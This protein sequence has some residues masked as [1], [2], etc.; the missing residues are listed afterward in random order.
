MTTL[1]PA[2]DNPDA[3]RPAGA[4]PVARLGG[5]GDI[6]AAVPWILGFHPRESLVLVS[7]KPPVGAGGPRVGLVLRLDLDEVRSSAAAGRAVDYLVEDGA[8]SLIVLVATDAPHRP[9]ARLPGAP[10]LRRVARAAQA[11][12][13][14][15]DEAVLVR[16]GR[17][18]AFDCQG[19]CCPADGTPYDC[20]TS[21][22]GAH[23]VLTGAV[24]RADREELAAS[25]AA[26]PPG[27]PAAVEAAAELDALALELARG[28]S[29][30]PGRRPVDAQPAAVR[31]FWEFV[32]A[33]RDGGAQDPQA[34]RRA[35]RRVAATLAAPVLRDA[36]GES[37]P[38][39]RLGEGCDALAEVLRACPPEW[40]ADPAA[41]LALTAWRAGQGALANVAVDVALAV[42]AEHSLALLVRS[43]VTSGLRGHDVDW[44]DDRW[45]TVV[46]EATRGAGRR[47]S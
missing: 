21:V 30:A 25:C 5:P 28:W 20:H 7:L 15:V 12:G 37:V 26:L 44:Y 11:R 19:P 41:L 36:V 16:D 35:A 33:A 31:G 13:L 2:S 3:P 29:R 18:W 46:A 1:P 38:P 40:A 22:V 42:D 17:W 10:L 32:V 45:D 4:P 23:H 8:A 34:R 14:E 27:S 6:A 9:G 43:I 47:A 24:L 39:E